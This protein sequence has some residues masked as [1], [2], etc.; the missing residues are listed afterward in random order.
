M[1]DEIGH[2]EKLVGNGFSDHG[3]LNITFHQTK[4]PFTYFA[5]KNSLFSKTG[6][7]LKTS[8]FSN[9]KR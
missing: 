5:K 2:S 7:F 1:F 9:L 6:S 4:G 3:P 8:C